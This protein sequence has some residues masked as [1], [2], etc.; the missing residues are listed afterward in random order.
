MAKN[1]HRIIKY[2]IELDTITT[3]DYTVEK[4][5]RL[6]EVFTDTFSVLGQ[7]TQAKILEREEV[8]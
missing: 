6:L 2:T 5:D 3:N 1:V 7:Q 8:K 4:F